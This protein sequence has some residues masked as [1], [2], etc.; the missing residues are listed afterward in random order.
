MTYDLDQ[1]EQMDYII[2]LANDGTVESCCTSD[3]FFK[4]ASAARL[5]DL[6]AN[7][8]EVK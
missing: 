8:H 4:K 6:A 3:E 5:E 2:H 7:L 1:A